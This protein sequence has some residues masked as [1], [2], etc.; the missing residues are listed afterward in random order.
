[1]SELLTLT[2]ALG[3]TYSHIF[4]LAFESDKNKK[5]VF[6]SVFVF[7]VPYSSHS[8]LCTVYKISKLILL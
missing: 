1:M 5:N 3:D 8:C 2:R 4:Q 7:I 6:F